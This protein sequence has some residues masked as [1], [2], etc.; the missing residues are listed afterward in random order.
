MAVRLA[1]AAYVLALLC[2]G[3]CNATG[4]ADGAYNHRFSIDAEAGSIAGIAVGMTEDQVRKLGLPY[5]VRSENWE[6]D[7]YKIYE[8][9]LSATVHLKC[10]FDLSNSLARI[11][12]SSSAVKDQ[13]GLSVGSQLAELERAYPSGKFVYG[14]ADGSY[15]NFLTGGRLIYYFNPEDVSASC[16]DNG[17]DCK[18]DDR[19]RA[20]TIAIGAA[21]AR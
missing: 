17:P 12:I 11:L 2:F 7:E 1:S 18:V 19:I 16:F 15:V 5:D 10:V 4:A 6:G 8:V 21:R 13:Y 20:T 14:E 9:H 3:G